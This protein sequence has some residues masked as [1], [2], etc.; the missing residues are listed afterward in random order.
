MSEIKTARE[1]HANLVSQIAKQETEIEELRSEV[2]KLEV[3]LQ[4][5]EELFGT[6]AQPEARPED[7]PAEAAPAVVQQA[8][9]AAPAE[10]AKAAEAPRP[11]DMSGTKVIQKDDT[12]QPKPAQQPVQSAE[13][14][15]VMPARQHRQV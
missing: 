13:A 7:R 1:R 11:A 14:P 12:V 5:A 3:F 15:R 8:T 10:T 6:S 4:L 9:E 2:D